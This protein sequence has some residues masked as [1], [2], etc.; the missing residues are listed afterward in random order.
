MRGA[1][2]QSCFRHQGELDKLAEIL[3]GGSKV[4]LR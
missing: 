3:G 1:L 2:I 4:E